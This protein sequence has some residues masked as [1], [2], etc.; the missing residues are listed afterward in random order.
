MKIRVVFLFFSLACATRLLGQQGFPFAD[1]IRVFKQQD[2]LHFPPGKG[3]LFIGSSSIRKWT[4]LESR[5]ADKPIIRRGVGGC[6]LGQLLD[7]YT[8]YILFPYEPRKI[9]IYAGENDIASGKS[10]QMV[11]EEFSKLQTL[12]HQKL[13]ATK[14]YFMSI[15]QG[16][17]RAKYAPEVN[18]ANA[19]IKAYLRHKRHSAYIDMNTAIYKPGTDQPDSSLFETDYIH[20][21]KTGYDRWQ[22]VLQPYVN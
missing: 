6:E 21:N 17:A 2:S 16:I 14:I 11:A 13:P 15:K 20:L 18:Q 8:P 22:K 1:E 9:F 3:I 5:F 7:F 12:I 19:L 4:D 10:P